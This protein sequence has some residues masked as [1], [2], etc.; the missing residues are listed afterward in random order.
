MQVGRQGHRERLL[1]AVRG[2]DAGLGLEQPIRA[3]VLAAEPVQVVAE[4]GRDV[5][6]DELGRLETIVRP[7]QMI[8][9]AREP[10]ITT[11][12]ELVG[13]DRVQRPAVRRPER[14]GVDLADAVGAVAGLAHGVDH[15]RQVG[16]QVDAIRADPVSPWRQSGEQR[17]T[18][19]HAE[20]VVDVGVI[21]VDAL[22]GKAVEV[23]GPDRQPAFR[24][25]LLPIAAEMVEA[26][27]V[28]HDD[29]EVGASSHS[30]L[31]WRAGA[32]TLAHPAEPAQVQTGAGRFDPDSG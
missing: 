22:G 27:L 8:D 31:L 25:Q 20:R 13:I 23:G 2:A 30:S 28:G 3:G 17:R 29:Q 6:A 18:R 24:S 10:E 4:C 19:W 32:H 15:C 7:G 12:G 26:V 14:A 1:G 9:P 5:R 11:L 21:A 16:A